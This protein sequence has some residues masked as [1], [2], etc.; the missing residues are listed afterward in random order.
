MTSLL[1][2]DINECKNETL[3]NCHDNATCYNS[4]GSFTCSCKAGFK[5]NGVSCQGQC[6]MHLLLIYNNVML[7]LFTSVLI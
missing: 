4:F 2:I 1:K 7:N 5:G 3:N 6:T